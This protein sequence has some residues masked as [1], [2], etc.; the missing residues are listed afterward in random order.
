M[1]FSAFFCKAKRRRK[2]KKSRTSLRSVALCSVA[3]HSL[4]VTWPETGYLWLIGTKTSL[5]VYLCHLQAANHLLVYLTLILNRTL[6]QRFPRQTAWLFFSLSLSFFCS[7]SSLSEDHA[8]I[9][10]RSSARDAPSCVSSHF[11]LTRTIIFFCLPP[12]PTEAANPE[13][14]A[15]LLRRIASSPTLPPQYW[16]ALQCL[17]RHFSRVCQNALKN[18]LSARSLG[19]IFSPVFFRQQPTR[20][21]SLVGEKKIK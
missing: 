16:L 9:S 14:C 13:E 11:L 12:P 5:K 6:S 17:L 21:T 1:N 10:C 3:L 15:Q 2:K 18:Q 7:I 4:A 19:E 8:F 20:W